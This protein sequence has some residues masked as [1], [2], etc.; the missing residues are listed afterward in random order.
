L[1]LIEEFLNYFSLDMVI[2]LLYAIII[3]FVGKI[4][5]RWI[6]NLILK[7]MAKSKVD[8]TLLKFLDSVIYGIFIIIVVI[9]SLG[10]LG[11]QTTSFIAI[12][13]AA[14]L[15]IALSFKDALSNISAGIMMIIFRPLQVG[16]TVTAGGETGT[17]EEIN[18]F[19]TVM[20]TA[21][22]KV[23]IL[24]NSNILGKNII[25]F[26][27]KETRRVEIIFSIGYEDDLKLAK[28][29]IIEVLTLDERI[30]KEP[31]FT[32]AVVSLGESSVDLTTRF[33]VKKE[34]FAKIQ[35][36][37]LERV[38]LS[39]DDK[40]ISIPYPQMDIHNK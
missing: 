2:N 9:T 15:A 26:S 5:S 10:M 4:A 7:A 37:I 20:K 1:N 24:P 12:L 36:D 14:G 25:N 22:N 6:T 33:W 40:N 18:I 23:I 21:D 32:V 8:K 13:G 3:F 34:D 27:R 17:I 16:E 35:F 29:T 19:Y 11:V 38:K 28:E 30:L 31:E 39:F